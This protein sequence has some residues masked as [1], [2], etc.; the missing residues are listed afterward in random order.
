MAMIGVMVPSV[1]ASEYMLP[2]EGEKTPVVLRAILNIENDY[3]FSAYVSFKVTSPSGDTEVL[4]VKV[5]KC[6]YASV[7]YYLDPDSE[8]GTY[9][10]NAT[11]KNE[12]IG[13]W[14]FKVSE[15]PSKSISKSVQIDLEDEGIEY[16]YGK[17][18]GSKTY[19]ISISGNSDVVEQL[20][21]YKADVKSP[22]GI[23][24]DISE[25]LDIGISTEEITYSLNFPLEKNS[26]L[27]QY[28][29]QI[30]AK[31]QIIA[32]RLF[33]LINPISASPDSSCVK[34]TITGIE[35]ALSDLNVEAFSPYDVLINEFNSS[36]GE[37]LNND[38]VFYYKISKSGFD[39]LVLDNICYENKSKVI[40]ETELDSMYE[41]PVGESLSIPLQI[42]LDKQDGYDEVDVIIIHNE[43]PVFS[44]NLEKIGESTYSIDF[45]ITSD[46]SLG[47]YEIFTKMK[48]SS[49]QFEAV[50]SSQGNFEVVDEIPLIPIAPPSKF[51]NCS[52]FAVKDTESRIIPNA[53]VK[54]LDNGRIIDEIAT[55]DSGQFK[56]NN[57]ADEF[58]ISKDGYESITV[59]NEC[60]GI[61]D[62][63]VKWM[64]QTTFNDIKS[65]VMQS[66]YYNVPEIT[67]SEIERVF[68]PELIRSLSPETQELLSYEHF[69]PLSFSYGAILNE[70]IVPVQDKAKLIGVYERLSDT[71]K[72]QLKNVISTLDDAERS[73]IQQIE[74]I[75]T[76]QSMKNEFKMELRKEV[77]YQRNAL[78]QYG[79]EINTITEGLIDNQKNLQQSREELSGGGCLIA[80]AAYGSELAPQVQ[81]LRE[82]RDNTVLQTTSGTTFMNGFN[83]FY[84]SFS[85]QI[86]DYERE[87]PVFKEM[88]KVSLT[89]LLISLTLLN[90]VEI[91]SEE[92]MLGYGIGIILLNI[93]MYFVAPAV[94]IISLK[95]RLDSFRGQ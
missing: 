63:K 32:E 91:D 56:N 46:Y 35:G 53:N 21:D 47:M 83:Q 10:A 28:E 7:T 75:D 36:T 49:G 68:V 20:Q 79:A 73:G 43:F 69:N 13:T 86:A 31:E 65:S 18:P 22:D 6:C 66:S 24:T 71:I 17:L 90:Y 95:K 88:V 72:Q 82:L 29:F 84:Y 45:P 40:F 39:T 9:N 74:R 11:F 70:P 52:L 48:D 77:E 26:M 60:F 58:T 23:S 37:F 1:F 89:P 59:K 62:P 50:L 27:G 81:F 94:L 87:N 41:R 57:K 16:T 55:G 14:V 85:P 33:T 3:L 67:Q 42:Y 80:T 51:S 30:S 61:E 34:Y 54:F 93:G 78:I 12:T 38:E 8:I 64:A 2:E 15:N 76:S 4:Q 19:L 5:T 92:E 44:G 25:F